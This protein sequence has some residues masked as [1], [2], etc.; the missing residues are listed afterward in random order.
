MN[1]LRYILLPCLAA[2]LLAVL[3]ACGPGSTSTRAFEEKYLDMGIAPRMM[4]HGDKL[5]YEGRL[6]EAHAA[7]LQAENQAY[8]ADMR[9]VARDRRI[10]V[11]QLIAAYEQGK[12]APLPNQQMPPKEEKKEPPKPE[13]V[14][15][16][17]WLQPS[18]GGGDGM[19]SSNN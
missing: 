7:Y 14:I 2:V 17:P 15:P 9:K 11:E 1:Q 16:P 6:R 19:N 3:A 13:P 8:T 5:Y 18:S 12:P 10:Y 4:A